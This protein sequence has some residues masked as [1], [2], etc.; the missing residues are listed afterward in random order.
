M[1]FLLTPRNCLNERNGEK[2]L[3]IRRTKLKGGNEKLKYRIADD[4]ELYEYAIHEPLAE[5]I[6]KYITA[7]ESEQHN[8]LDTLLVQKPHYAYLKTIQKV[9][10]RY[11]TYAYLTTCL[12]HFYEEV[13]EPSPY[14]VSYICLGD[15]RHIAMTNLILSG[16]SPV[17]CRELAG[18]A[19]IDTSSHYYSNISNLVKCITIERYRKMKG[20]EATI[21]G[22]LHYP[23]KMISKSQSVAD[24]RCTSPAY[25]EG[26]ID[27][28]LMVVGDNGH[29][30]DCCFCRYF[31]PDSPGAMFNFYDTD[32]AKKRINADC[33]Y[34]I[35]MIELV[36]KGL[37][38]TEDISFALLKLQRSS[39]HYGM[40]LWEGIERGDILWQDP[41][42]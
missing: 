22:S 27:D 41:V 7:T 13:I 39:E 38:Y 35:R 12:R 33:K 10:S 23:V 20:T 1:E 42:K 14:E 19:N 26:R 34:L 21:E 3:T 11:Y 15:T 29:I 8:R 32:A 16:G 6:Q 30:G 5:E 40:C 24:G 17:I 25:Q 37:G 18:H 31:L 36:R 4:Y 9:K 2:I 28:C